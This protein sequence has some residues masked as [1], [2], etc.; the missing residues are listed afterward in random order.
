[1]RAREIDCER[2]WRESERELLR[3][4]LPRCLASRRERS[5]ESRNRIRA[6]RAREKRERDGQNIDVSSEQHCIL[7]LSF[8]IK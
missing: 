1:M 2:E 6:K 5:F 8:G 4:A 7:Q 3:A